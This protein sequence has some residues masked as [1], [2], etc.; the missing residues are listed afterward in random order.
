MRS[1][2]LVPLLLLG[3]QP[4]AVLPAPPTMG[5]RALILA[6]ESESEIVR[7]DAAEVS[8][9]VAGLG[10]LAV[11]TISQG[12]LRVTALRYACSLQELG[13]KP[14]IQELTESGLY[15][16]VPVATG[17]A[18]LDIKKDEAL[19]WVEDDPLAPKLESALKKLPLPAGNLCR[20]A[21]A[22]FD[23]IPVVVAADGMTGMTGRDVVSTVHLGE[24][25]ILVTTAPVLPGGPPHR[26]FLVSPD[27]A[28]TT[29]S[30]AYPGS[31]NQRLFVARMGDGELLVSTEDG[32][33]A[34]GTLERG[35]VRYGPEFLRDQERVLAVAPK[36]DSNDTLWIVVRSEGG[37]RLIEHTETSSATVSRIRD[38]P[39][40][41]AALSANHWLVGTFRFE[42]SSPIL[43]VVRRADGSTSVMPQ[44]L[45]PALEGYLDRREAALAIAPAPDGRALAATSLTKPFSFSGFL[46]SMAE[47]Q[48]DRWVRL[49]RGSRFEVGRDGL[50]LVEEVRFILAPLT[51]VSFAIGAFEYNQN[52]AFFYERNVG[53]CGLATFPMTVQGDGRDV[54]FMGSTLIDDHS[55][56]FMS[57]RT[58]A[59]G[60]IL[61]RKGPRSS[62][63]GG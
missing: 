56:F 36:I 51:S 10:G 2:A 4:V 49:P 33:V 31:Y 15:P 50:Q 20:L 13:L 59:P 7:L 27:G 32:W 29:T 34:R 17:A 55:V 41:F 47:Q 54:V 61:R 24:G 9:D 45:P 11:N 8:G 26:A 19:S 44:P 14:G 62:C 6:Y 30:I 42:G 52:A 53:P 57:G 12:S 38:R 43:S 1:A 3:C 48:G 58:D 21:G 28:V 39:V 23:K 5:A 40:S 63:L 46:G 25:R 16:E 22:E 37:A 35:F 18:T 60:L